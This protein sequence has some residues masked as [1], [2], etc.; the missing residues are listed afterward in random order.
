MRDGSTR[1]PATTS[2]PRTW[3]PERVQVQHWRQHHRD[4]VIRDLA[5]RAHGLE[6]TRGLFLAALDELHVT[7]EFD[8]LVGAAARVPASQ[9]PRLI[10]IALFLRQSW[11]PED[12]WRVA[13]R[14]G[15]DV[16]RLASQP[17]RFDC[18]CF[19]RRRAT[20]RHG[21]KADARPHAAKP[22]K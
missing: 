2:S 15:I 17:D 6:W 20:R 22:G 4:E 11:W 21:V 12:L 7:D 10:A 13:A 3:T 5:A 14:V 16:G 1:R 19:R 8:R 18:D 9:Y